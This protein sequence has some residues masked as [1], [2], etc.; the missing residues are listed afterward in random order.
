MSDWE[1]HAVKYAD[2]NARTRADSFLFDDNHDAPHPMDYF[3]WVLRR[4]TEVILVDTGYDSLEAAARRRPIRQDPVAS[5]APL[6]L[7]PDDITQIIVTHL[8]YDHAG[9]LHLF[10]NA[11][12]HMQA[13]E[14]AYATG[15]CMCHDTLSMPFTAGHICEAVKRLYSGQV[16]FHDG[17]A[18]VVDGVTV[19][20][21][22]GHSRGLQAVRVRTTAGW[23]VLASDAAHF[24]ENLLARKPFPIVVDLEDM[25]AGFDTL[26]SLASRPELIVPGHDPIVTQV[27]PQGVA[28]HIWRLDPG[29][30]AKVTI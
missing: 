23:L 12:L 10:P 27:F 4:G 20:C 25:L 14:M 8:H 15:P 11:K 24:Y 9:G 26:V 30:I 3:I 29:P 21:I 16:V 2:R 6:G 19:H 28:D 1:V 13:A 17:D 18:Q 7:R 5:L 22:G